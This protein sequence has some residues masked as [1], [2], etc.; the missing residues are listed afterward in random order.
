MKSNILKCL[1]AMPSIARTVSLINTSIVWCANSSKPMR[2][3]SYLEDLN[4]SLNALESSQALAPEKNFESSE[5]LDALKKSLHEHRQLPNQILL[6]VCKT[7][8]K[9]DLGEKEILDYILAKVARDASSFSQYEVYRIYRFFLD[10]GVADEPSLNALKIRL[11]S[12]YRQM[13]SWALSFAIKS[14]C[15]FDK[16]NT[17]ND[18]LKLLLHTLLRKWPKRRAKIIEITNIASAIKE[19]VYR[20]AVLAKRL[21]SET[22]TLHEKKKVSVKDIQLV[23]EC[24]RS[25]GFECSELYNICLTLSMREKGLVVFN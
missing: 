5:L 22:L 13:D 9:C 2:E 1:L 19:A 8:W 18:S 7:Y 4:R 16:V 3:K 24:L 11:M 6:K 10:I 20:D 15:F 21:L 17:N 23:D 25:I 12:I 14:I